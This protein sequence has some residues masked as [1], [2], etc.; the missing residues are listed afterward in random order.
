MKKMKSR[1]KTLFFCSNK[2]RQE[3]SF[4]EKMHADDEDFEDDFC[5]NINP[6]T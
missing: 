3:K 1:T 6:W 4:F 2:K 5:K